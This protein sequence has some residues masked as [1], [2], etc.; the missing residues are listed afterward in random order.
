MA[1]DELRLGA[2]VL[3]AGAGSRFGGHKLAAELDDLP[4]LQHVLDMLSGVALD[5][6][7][8]VTAPD[9]RELH[10]IRWRSERRV[11]NP[12]PD[13]GLSSS[14]Q[15]ALAECVPD[16]LDGVFILLGDQP[17]TSA[18]TLAALLTAAQDAPGDTLAVLPDYADGGG[19]N[20]VLLMRSGFALAAGL[21]G[22]RG[23][24]ALLAARPDVVRRVPL[25]GSNPDVDTPA[26]LRALRGDG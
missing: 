17:R 4:L 14:L 25:P 8:V 15:V 18:A 22:D 5:V 13:R 11:I 10:P 24:G 19:P 1:E 26:D 3:A 21:S 6:V 23:L 20:P 12:D 9:A 2:I 16:D 7:V